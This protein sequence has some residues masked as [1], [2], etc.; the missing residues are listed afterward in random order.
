MA[1]L[2]RNGGD[3]VHEVRPRRGGRFTGKELRRLTGGTRLQ[4][5]R[6]GWRAEVKV[7][8]WKLDPVLGE[9]VPVDVVLC[10]EAELPAP[11]KRWWWPLTVVAQPVLDV[12]PELPTLAFSLL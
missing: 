12:G 6:G 1:V 4:I 10:R 5:L 11:A 2:L 8:G 3:E 7:I 9:N